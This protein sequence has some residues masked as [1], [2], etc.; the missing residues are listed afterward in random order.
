VDCA[1]HEIGAF[2]IVLLESQVGVNQALQDFV[3]L[4]AQIGLA[5]GRDVRLGGSRVELLQEGPQGQARDR[6]EQDERRRA[7]RAAELAHA[8]PINDEEALLDIYAK[9]LAA[10]QGAFR[11]EIPDTKVVGGGPISRVDVHGPIATD[12]FRRQITVKPYN[13][14]TV[15]R[16][17]GTYGTDGANAWRPWSENRP[18]CTSWHLVPRPSS[19]VK[20]KT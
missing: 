6:P 5:I 11:V 9:V 19:V 2:L 15:P 17:T 14:G 1:R 16:T 13:V 18:T 8:L 3:P 12:Q 7:D 4:L 10:S 20:S